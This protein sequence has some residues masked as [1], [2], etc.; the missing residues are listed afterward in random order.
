MKLKNVVS[1]FALFFSLSAHAEFTII[2][3]NCEFTS[4]SPEQQALE[5]V[6]VRR[7][8]LSLVGTDNPKDQITYQGFLFRHATPDV[9]ISL[10]DVS[11]TPEV[12][13]I[14]HTTVDFV[15][16]ADFNLSIDVKTLQGTFA[17]KNSTATQPVKCSVSGDGKYW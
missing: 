1:L 8:Y 6:Q 15:D 5:Y 17:Y 11:R 3:T 12:P 4:A 2:L 9:Q 14:P 10:D 16:G 13:A 7:T